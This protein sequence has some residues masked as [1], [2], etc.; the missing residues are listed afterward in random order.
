M[1]SPRGLL[2]GGIGAMGTGT[3][4]EE[5]DVVGVVVSGRGGEGWRA[6]FWVGGAVGG[7]RGKNKPKGLNGN[8]ERSGGWRTLRYMLKDRRALLACGT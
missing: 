7:G 1:S 4:S 2:L 6:P 5:V 3:A 8:F